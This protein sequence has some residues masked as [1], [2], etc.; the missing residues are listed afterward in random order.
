MA[1]TTRPSS[2]T[3][4]HSK[5]ALRYSATFRANGLPGPP[6]LPG[7]NRPS[8][9]RPFFDST[10]SVVA[11]VSGVE[12]MML[13]QMRRLDVPPSLPPL[14]AGR[15]DSN[16]AGLYHTCVQYG[17]RSFCGFSQGGRGG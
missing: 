6:G 8:A 17:E 3:D 7:A 10:C 16:L 9:W 1:A 12:F 15:W 4:T 11:W 13:L 2:S 5:R 14:A